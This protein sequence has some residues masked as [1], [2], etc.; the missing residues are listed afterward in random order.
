MQSTD[1]PA[2]SAKLFAQDTTGTYVRSLP[3]TTADPNAASFALGF[4][5]NTFTDE[6][7]GGSPPDGRDFNG[8]LSYLHSVARWFQAGGV[9]GYDGTYQTAI[10][11][12]PLGAVVYSASKPGVRYRSTTNN[13]TTNPDTGGAGWVTETTEGTT[14]GVNWRTWLRS[15]GT[16]G[17]RMSA[18]T[19]LFYSESMQIIGF[20]FTLSALTD[21]GV[22][23]V[24][25]TDSNRAD[26]I[27]QIFNP[28][29]TG[30]S[31]R[32]QFMGGGTEVWPIG[33]RWFAE[34]VL[35]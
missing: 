16:R 30:L 18:S 9:A 13:N 14:S 20:P 10:G 34:G 35:A 28:T 27:A 1:Q 32:M 8:I 5:P 29:T 6:G 2:R 17:I 23:T 25:Q 19:A 11:G 24:I 31:V 3:Q 21:Y 15:D 7:A 26:Q 4:P 22:S 12:Y 33:A